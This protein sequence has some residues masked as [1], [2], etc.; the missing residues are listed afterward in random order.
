MTYSQ[1]SSSRRERAYILYYTDRHKKYIDIVRGTYIAT[2]KKEKSLGLETSSSSSTFLGILF[3]SILLLHVTSG[4]KAE[5]GKFWGAKLSTDEQQ[6][7]STE[8]V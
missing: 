5:K 2:Y 7:H 4:E 3:H 8:N 1:L 6:Q